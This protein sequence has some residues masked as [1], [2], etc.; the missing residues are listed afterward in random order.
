MLFTASLALTL[1]GS[2]YLLTTFLQSSPLYLPVTSLVSCS[3]SL[4][5]ILGLFVFNNST[6]ECGLYNI[7][8]SHSSVLF[9][10]SYSF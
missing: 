5:A 10:L 1:Q 8:L 2:L 9:S 4:D 7:C 6:R 3:M